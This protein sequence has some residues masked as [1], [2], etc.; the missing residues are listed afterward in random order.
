MAGRVAGKDPFAVYCSATAVLS[1]G[2]VGR[3][4]A[5][6][7]RALALGFSSDLGVQA[8]FAQSERP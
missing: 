5:G 6:P 2:V 4:L 8:A 3:V 1:P 7:A